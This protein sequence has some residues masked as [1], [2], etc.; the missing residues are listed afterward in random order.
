MTE[1]NV[2]ILVIKSLKKAGWKIISFDY[3]QSGTGK[4]IKPDSESKNLGGFIPDIVSFKD[5]VVLFW[6]NKDRFVYEDF[7]KIKTIKGSNNFQKPI[8][9]FLSGY[10]YNYIYYGISIPKIDT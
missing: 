3:P 9:S 1:E 8:Q 10:K 5:G 7:V 4:L 6:E 2:T